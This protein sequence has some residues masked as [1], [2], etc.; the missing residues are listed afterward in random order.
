MSNKD[1]VAASF[2]T[3]CSSPCGLT[4]LVP[5][6]VY[7]APQQNPSTVTVA[8]FH[9]E[10]DFC[11]TKQLQELIHVGV[12]ISPRFNES[13]PQR[14]CKCPTWKRLTRFTHIFLCV[15]LW[16]TSSESLFEV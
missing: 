10:L 1:T 11:P 16:E 2:K 7:T 9:L 8:D 14:E 4:L 6:Q 5:F 3:S 15:A 12:S 13:G